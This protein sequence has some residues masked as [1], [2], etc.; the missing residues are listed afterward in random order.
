M[1]EK[2]E[3]SRKQKY[4]VGQI[5]A[6]P[7]PDGRFAY[8]KVFNDFDIGVFDF[9]SDQ[10]EPA[11]R[12]VDNKF[13]FPLMKK[14]FEFTMGMEKTFG[15]GLDFANP[16]SSFIPFNGFVFMMMKLRKKFFL[17]FTI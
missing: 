13:L 14:L 16:I 3:P 17:I 5:V 9:V 7:L 15:V 1:T 6:I 4:K 10:M 2:R 11:E 12:V 8:G